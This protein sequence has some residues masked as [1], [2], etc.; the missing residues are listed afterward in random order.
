M[1]TKWETSI[2][3]AAINMKSK[4]QKLKH[5]VSLP[6]SM[7]CPRFDPIN[8]H[9][10][11]AAVKPVS[12]SISDFDRHLERPCV[13]MGGGHRPPTEKSYQFTLSRSSWTK[14]GGNLWNI[15]AIIPPGKQALDPRTLRIINSR[16]SR[17]HNQFP[18]E[19]PTVPDVIGRSDLACYG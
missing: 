15:K 7:K 4:Q 1:P 3:K 13:G 11:C 9:P 5:G 6:F 19:L 2:V 16:S 12:H 8:Q 14:G 17:W 18:F 10:R